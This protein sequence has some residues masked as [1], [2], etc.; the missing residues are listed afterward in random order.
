MSEEPAI[1]WIYILGPCQGSRLSKQVSHVISIKV[2]CATRGIQYIPVTITVH[3][4]ILCDS[5]AHSC[6]MSP[7]GLPPLPRRRMP[8]GGHGM[9]PAPAA[10]ATPLL[11]EEAVETSMAP[12]T[13]TTATALVC[14]DC[15]EDC[16]AQPWA[17]VS[18]GITLCLN[19]AG[20]A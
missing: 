9:E 13:A 15:D 18:Y 4:G 2:Y 5:R 10:E 20:G 19:C 7:S 3:T 14:F 1:L 17:S 11:G 8:G 6:I 12:T 16:A